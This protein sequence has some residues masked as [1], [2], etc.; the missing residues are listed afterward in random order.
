MDTKSDVKQYFTLGV[1]GNNQLN[2]LASFGWEIQYNS[3]GGILKDVPLPIDLNSENESIYTYDLHFLIS[4]WEFPIYLQFDF[5]VNKKSSIY[6][7]SGPSISFAS[8]DLST[9]RKIDLLFTKEEYWEFKRESEE[10]L[11]EYRE[12]RGVYQ[13][14]KPR[15]NFNWG[16]GYTYDRY[17]FELRYNKMNG[18]LGENERFTRIRE[19]SYSVQF[20][21]G[22]RIFN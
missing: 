15:L 1:Y 10:S 11:F 22:I 9:I 18:D 14:R 5:P 21:I 19:R 20:Q 16:I 4:Y 12:N 2:E 13:F 3:K 6:I 17:L 8:Q 7:I